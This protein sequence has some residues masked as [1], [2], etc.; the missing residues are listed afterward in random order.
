M[1]WASSTAAAFAED[2]Y[3]VTGEISAKKQKTLGASINGCG[4]INGFCPYMYSD[5]FRKKDMELFDDVP[6]H[7]YPF[8]A[9][10]DRIDQDDP[11]KKH[12][13]GG[14][15]TASSFDKGYYYAFTACTY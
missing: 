12:E 3:K 14:A 15:G 11:P 9:M 8:P 4:R 2:Q 13:K 6:H 10:H 5:S 7:H 1:L